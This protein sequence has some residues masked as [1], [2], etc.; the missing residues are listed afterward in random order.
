MQISTAINESVLHICDVLDTKVDFADS[1][2]GEIYGSSIPV[3]EKT[4]E[5]EKEIQFF[6]YFKKEVLK[7]AADKLLQSSYT[8]DDL[9]D[10]SR[11]LAN[12]I[13]GYA[14]NLLN[15]ASA[16]NPYSLGVPEFLGVVEHFHIEFIESKIYKIN[17]NVLKI[18]YKIAWQKKN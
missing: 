18:G 15:N 5:G 1:I 4:E 2:E 9:D 10:L 11:E 3:Y 16:H 12:Q 17:G 14:K 13:I 7:D 8:E 6:L